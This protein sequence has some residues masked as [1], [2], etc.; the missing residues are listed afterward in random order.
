ML[1]HHNIRLTFAALDY[2]SIMLQIICK[3]HLFVKQMVT[4][5][6]QV[7]MIHN[8]VTVTEDPQC[9]TSMNTKEKLYSYDKN[10]RE[11]NS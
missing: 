4:Y 8:I 9:I 5:T 3:H 1:S 6:A 2:P 7:C 10:L 11:K